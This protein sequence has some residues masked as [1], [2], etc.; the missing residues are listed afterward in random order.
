MRAAPRA[1]RGDNP[2]DPGYHGNVIGHAEAVLG[3]VL[4]FAMPA[5]MCVSRYFKAN[6]MLGHRDRGLIAESVFAVLRRKLEY[7]QLAQS[8]TGSLTRRM[9]LLGLADAAGVEP[10]AAT[11]DSDERTWLRRVG[12]IDRS[13]MPLATR[14]NLP[15]WIFSALKLRFAD[16]EV[17]KIAAVLNKPAPLDLRV[18]TMRTSRDDALQA[19][20][21]AGLEAEPT[22]LAPHGIRVK[23]KPALGAQKIFLDGRIEVQDEGSQLLATL[24]GPKRGEFVVDFCAGA[25]GKTLALGDLMRSTGRLYAL[26]VSAKRLARLKPRLAR[27]GLSNVHPV[28]IESERDPKLKR[29]AGKADRVLIDAPCSG[30]GTLRRNPDLKWRQSLDSI[31]E[32][33]A[34]QSSILEAASRLVKPGGRLVYATCSLLRAENHDVVDAFLATH[35]EFEIESATGIL[36]RQGIIAGDK[37]D[38]NVMLELWPHRTN[39]DGFFAAVL[40]KREAPVVAA[41]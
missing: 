17:E 39:T 35:A 9:I 13:T 40:K 3:D 28:L 2:H 41:E 5:D 18:N 20:R 33:T 32:L 8:G 14:S 38:D 4:E 37:L 25:G 15:D 30:L 21:A 23:G 36:K 11:L 24:V 22:A 12:T 29:M 7:A 6:P 34:K 10:I 31:V 19:M 26:D 16:A 27:S 1:K